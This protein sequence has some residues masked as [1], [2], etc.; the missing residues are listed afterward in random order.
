[1][2]K[3]KDKI[4]KN[5]ELIK[6]TKKENLG[7]IAESFSER[8]SGNHLCDSHILKQLLEKHPSVQF[9]IMSDDLTKKTT[10]CTECMHHIIVYDEHVCHA[11]STIETDYVTG[12]T[13]AQGVLRCYDV[14]KSGDC[15]D[16]EKLTKKDNYPKICFLV[17]FA[18]ISLEETCSVVK[19]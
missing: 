5:P 10:I 4:E 1:M 8:H 2:K 6:N 12:I 19:T 14:N 17:D 9:G 15:P 13:K 16:F 3:G 7:I 18:P 11:K